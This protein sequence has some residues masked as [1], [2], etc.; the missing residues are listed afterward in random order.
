MSEIPRDLI[1]QEILDTFQE[2]IQDYKKHGDCTFK[3][4]DLK[5][6]LKWSDKTEWTD[7]FFNDNFECYQEFADN[8]VSY[9]EKLSKKYRDHDVENMYFFKFLS[10]YYNIL[11]CIQER[12]DYIY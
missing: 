3:W 4:I 2:I 1:Q 10:D 12:L 11:R 5:D 9:T 7:K 6:L 8:I